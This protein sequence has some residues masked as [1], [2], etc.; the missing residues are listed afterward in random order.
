MV[1]IFITNLKRTK[2]TAVISSKNNSSFMKRKYSSRDD[3]AVLQCKIP[4]TW[5]NNIIYLQ[6]KGQY[7]E[8]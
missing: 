8:Q 2:I 7:L 3:T 1:Y 6:K 5:K 4:D